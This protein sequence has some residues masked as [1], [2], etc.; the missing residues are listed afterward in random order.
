MKRPVWI[1]DILQT[2][3]SFQRNVSSQNKILTV[4]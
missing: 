4:T 3:E 1:S 2:N